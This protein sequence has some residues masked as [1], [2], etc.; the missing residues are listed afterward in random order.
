MDPPNGAKIEISVTIIEFFDSTIN[1]GHSKIDFKL[2]WNHLGV[3]LDYFGS[4]IA[5]KSIEI[6]PAEC[7]ERLNNDKCLPGV[8]IRLAVT[9][10]PELESAR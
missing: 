8:A 1:V 9:A 2:F 5:P 6:G 4:K 10:R 7:A 3:I